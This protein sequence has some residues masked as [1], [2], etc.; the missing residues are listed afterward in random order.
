MSTKN[1]DKKHLEKNKPNTFFSIIKSVLIAYTFT[2]F[3]FIIYGAMLTY[4][5][6]TEKHTQL[7][8]MITTVISVLICGFLTAK[9]ASKNGLIVGMLS[10][11]FYALIMILISICVSPS[12]SLNKKTIMI[13]VLSL[14]G[15]GLGGIFG[16][17]L[18]QKLIK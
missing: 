8:V 4:T 9:N 13:I 5:E 12:I 3:V 15:G 1:F 17:N 7:I 11:S 14:S 18:K 16:I 2:I 6:I 10:G